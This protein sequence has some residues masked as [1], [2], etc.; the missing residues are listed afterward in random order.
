MVKGPPND[1]LL[2]RGGEMK[3]D[4]LAISAE[5]HH[6]QYGEFALSFW[7]VP[8]L[9]AKQIA[10]RVHAQWVNAVEPRRHPLPHPKIRY[11]SAGA[12]RQLGYRV[13]YSEPRPMHVSV[14]FP[15]AP[16]AKDWVRIDE[17]FGPS[18]DNPVKQPPRRR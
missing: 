18:A 2:V 6:E 5:A 11:A 16:S 7:T 4:S 15:S 1:A 14:I 10:E 8:G 17:V 3:A 9:D 12:L 13:V